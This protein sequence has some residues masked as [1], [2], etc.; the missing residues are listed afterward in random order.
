MELN[1]LKLI[2][3]IYFLKIFFYY[4]LLKYFHMILIDHE[5]QCLDKQYLS[6]I[7]HNYIKFLISYL[8]I[9]YIMSI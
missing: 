7:L 8:H 5:I 4:Y 3:K 6:S 2:N 9:Y 1:P